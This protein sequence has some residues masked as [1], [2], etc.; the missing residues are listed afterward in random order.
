MKDKL[1]DEDV[2]VNAYGQEYEDEDAGDAGVDEHKDKTDTKD[3]KCEAESD[4]RREGGGV[5]KENEAKGEKGEK[6]EK[7]RK[8]VLEHAKRKD[9]KADHFGRDFLLFPFLPRSELQSVLSLKVAS[10][11]LKSLV[12]HVFAEKWYQMK[13]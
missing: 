8:I 10:F 7:E 5:E 12:F 11:E 2:E 9:R 13:A 6:D 3:K 1:G 4:D